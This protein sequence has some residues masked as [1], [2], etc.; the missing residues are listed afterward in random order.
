[1]KLSVLFLASAILPGALYAQDKLRIERVGLDGYYSSSVPTPVRIHIP[2]PSQSGRV[3]L[4][5]FVNSNVYS[6]QERWFQTGQFEKELSV[7]AG[8]AQETAIP[9]LLSSN[10]PNRLRLE[11]T[12]SQRRIV[13]EDRFEVD[14]KFR[15]YESMVAI[16][17]HDDSEC[18]AAQTQISPIPTG[19]QNR[20]PRPETLKFLLSKDLPDDWLACRVADA[21]VIAGPISGITPN[22]SKALED[23]LRSG[24]I[25]VLLEEEAGAGAFLSDYRKSTL[26]AKPLSIGK[27]RLYRVSSLASKDLSSLFSVGEDGMHRK[28]LWN[29]NGN[30]PQTDLLLDHVSVP[31]TFPRLRWLLIWMGAYILVIAPLN[32]TLL[33]RLRRLEWGWVTILVTFLSLLGWSLL[34]QFVPPAKTLHSGRR[35]RLLDGWRKCARIQGD[36][37][38]HFFSYALAGDDDIG[39][40]P[41][42]RSGGIS[43]GQYVRRLYWLGDYGQH[44]ARGRAGGGRWTA[45][46]NRNPDATMVEREFSCGRTLRLRRHRALGFLYRTEERDRTRVQAGNLLGF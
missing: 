26:S 41:C 11:E 9:I 14:P 1:M 6:Y 18:L 37:I 22:Q 32:F 2:T 17:C 34:Q 10:E 29:P 45:A 20:F 33:K 16:Y 38:S 12:D 31:F 3:R 36:G 13:A 8:Q 21:W 19:D 42:A 46:E 44:G 7:V 35:E 5:L 39:K 40:R 24:G 23:Y 15:K 28:I 27:G 25:V 4:V 30:H 43:V